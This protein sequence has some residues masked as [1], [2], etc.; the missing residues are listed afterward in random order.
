LHRLHN[1]LIHLLLAR[2]HD[3][4]RRLSVDDGTTVNVDTLTA[5]E[6]SILTG[7]ED[8]GGSQLGW[9]TDSANRSGGVV[10]GLHLLLVHGGGLEW[11][12]YGSRADG[13][14]CQLRSIGVE[15]L[16]LLDSDTLGDEL[17]GE[18]SNHGDLGALGHGVVEEGWGSGV[19]D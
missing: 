3:A 1:L 14:D 6:R 9:L 2:N 16:S 18:Y 15:G 4:R 12:P 17:V 10:P 13:A 8:V 11:C 7:E 19:C 5:D